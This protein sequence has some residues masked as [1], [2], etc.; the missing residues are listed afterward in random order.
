ML[1]EQHIEKKE[2]YELFVNESQNIP[3]TLYHIIECN[4][5]DIYE[6]IQ[7]NWEKIKL[8][9]LKDLNIQ[10]INKSLICALSNQNFTYVDFIEKTLF[11]HIRRKDHY[12]LQRTFTIIASHYYKTGNLKKLRDLCSTINYPNHDW[13]MYLAFSQG[14]VTKALNERS[15][16]LLNSLLSFHDKKNNSSTFKTLTPEKDICGEAFNSMYY[17][18]LNKDIP[19]LSITCDERLHNILSNNFKDVIFIPKTPPYRQK[20][21]PEKFNKIHYYL[22]RYLDN[23]SYENTIKNEFI[24][25]DYSKYS[26]H[27]KI[28]LNRQKGWLKP[29]RKLQDLWKERLTT[30]EKNKVIVISSNST[31]SSKARNIHMVGLEYWEKIFQIEN[32]IFININ[33]AVSRTQCTKLEKEHNIKIFTPDINLFDDF[34]NLLAIMSISDYAILPANNL[35]DFAATVGLKTI[36]FSPTNIMKSW[37]YK[38]ENTYIFSDNVQ[39]IFSEDNGNDKANMVDKAYHIIKND[40]S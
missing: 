11:K 31:F 39:F 5:S 30:E 25:L 22:R 1:C 3:S 24:T 15:G 32:C 10:L 17:E 19:N 28:K 23:S 2:L 12:K 4:Y 14:H 34:D 13:K 33:A 38:E 21:N 35:M 40:L 9:V 16:M 29:S 36:V 27:K 37:T 8:L 6:H 20:T 18:V 7:P 26:E